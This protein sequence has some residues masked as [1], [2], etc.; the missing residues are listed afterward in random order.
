MYG[1][2]LY[3]SLKATDITYNHQTKSTEL[4]AKKNKH[5]EKLL[6][7]FDTTWQPEPSQCSFKEMQK[8]IKKCKHIKWRR[9]IISLRNCTSC[10]S[11]EMTS[12][13]CIWWPW[14]A[15]C[16]EDDGQVLADP[17]KLEHFALC[18]RCLMLLY[19]HCRWRMEF[20]LCVRA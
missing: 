9:K 16:F 20:H 18:L 8:K 7:L 17:L 1:I 5:R 12:W 19:F 13:M 2:I 6:F 3:F 4:F 15:A 10:H 14:S 11:A